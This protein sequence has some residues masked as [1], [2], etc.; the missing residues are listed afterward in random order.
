[1]RHRTK[2]HLLNQ[3]QILE[4]L[5]RAEVGRMG[6]FS[7]N[8]F[9]Y[10]VPMHFVY[11]DNKVYLH[12]LPMGEKI[13]NI[14]YN[15]NVCFEID[16]MLSLLDKGVENPCDVN[17][18]F[19]SVIMQG[20]AFIVDNFYEKHKALFKIIEKFTPHLLEKEIPRKMIDGTAVIRIDIVKCVGRYYK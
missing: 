6:T 8:G 20:H 10:I 5:H 19:N 1:M 14:K 3:K 4:F 7:Q 13:D 2:T 12:G 16:E 15:Q 17:T 18:E 11:F 9:P